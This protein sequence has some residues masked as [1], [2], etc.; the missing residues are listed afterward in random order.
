MIR[1][2][3]HC[4]A[5]GGPDQA[6]GGLNRRTRAGWTRALTRMGFWEQETQLT[7]QLSRF[8]ERG[9]RRKNRME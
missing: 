2:A 7:H 4:Q 5:S 6:G 8:G 9:A 1:E 3:G